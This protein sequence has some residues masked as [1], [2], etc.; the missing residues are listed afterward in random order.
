MTQAGG[1]PD[2]AT[3]LFAFVAAP[4]RDDARAALRRHLDAVAESGARV[5]DTALFAVLDGEGD[6]LLVHELALRADLAQVEAS[7]REQFGADALLTTARFERVFAAGDARPMSAVDGYLFLADVDVDPAVDHTEFNRWY[8]EAHVPDVGGVGLERAQRFRSPN[9]G[10]RY[11]ASYEIASPDVL[12]TPEL[13]RV[14]GFH[15]FTP[16]IRR[17]TRTLGE[18]IEEP[19]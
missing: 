12:T 8:D 13:A 18:P 17:L 10:D 2:G 9:G 19:S 4:D 6:V 11:L 16:S 1:T 15:H 3:V 14:R 7:I 5:T